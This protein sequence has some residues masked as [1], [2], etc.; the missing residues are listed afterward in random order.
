MQFETTQTPAQ[1]FNM[2]TPKD[3]IRK[4]IADPNHVITDEE[5]KRLVVGVLPG[6]TPSSPLFDGRNLPA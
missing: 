6:A 5:L 1:N 2:M 3:L 4:H